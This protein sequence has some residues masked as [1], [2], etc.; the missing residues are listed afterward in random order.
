[1]GYIFF[2]R[3]KVLFVC[4]FFAFSCVT[5]YNDADDFIN[6]INSKQNFWKAGRNFHEDTPNSQ[7]RNL[8]GL[9]QLSQDI[10]DKVIVHDISD[11]ELPESFDARTQW[12]H[13]RSIGEIPDQSECGSCW[14]RKISQLNFV[15]ETVCIT[16]KYFLYNQ[17]SSSFNDFIVT[18]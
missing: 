9:K 8:L 14:V 5:A 12:P 11:D 1:M 2:Y 18:F 16:C 13:C 10:A 17:S 15:F 6:E 7:L 4:V 3:M